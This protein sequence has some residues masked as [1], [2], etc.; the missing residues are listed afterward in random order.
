MLDCNEQ[1]SKCTNSCINL[2]QRCFQYSIVFVSES[3]GVVET[4]AWR[5][6]NG[7][8]EISILR[9]WTFRFVEEALGVL[10][11]PA[12]GREITSRFFISI[13]VWGERPEDGLFDLSKCLNDMRIG[14]N[15]WFTKNIKDRIWS[16]NDSNEKNDSVDNQTTISEKSNWNYQGKHGGNKPAEVE[17]RVSR[18]V[19]DSPPEGLW[20][21]CSFF[22]FTFLSSVIFNVVPASIEVLEVV[23]FSEILYLFGE[24]VSFWDME[25]DCVFVD[26]M[27]FKN[28]KWKK[29]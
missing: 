24:R 28:Q 12:C 29:G 25:W 18:E 2:V 27:R 8:F 15:S 26:W 3:S 14:L 19:V 6:G 16:S 9:S 11:L 20:L 17:W 4:E 1:L 21:L 5:G 7:A 22:F 10:L 23:G 13:E